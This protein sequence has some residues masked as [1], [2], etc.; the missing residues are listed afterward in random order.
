MQKTLTKAFGLILAFGLAAALCMTAIPGAYAATSGD[1]EVK[2]QADDSNIDV[3]VPLV[4]TASIKGD[5]TLLY[6]TDAKL[7]NNSIFAI[8]VS[9][10]GAASVSPFKL[11]AKSGFDASSD[12]NAF[13]TEVTPPSGTA[14]D[15]A[16]PTP[17]AGQWNMAKTGAAGNELALTFDG[18]IKNV[19]PL[20]VTATKAYTIT[21]TVAPGAAS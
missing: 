6:P 8:N 10:I 21:W 3:T 19:D 13:W 11:V 5:G 20:P 18:K 12:T 2:M 7:V 15:L 1:T 14:V 16:N 9:G 17:V 4:I